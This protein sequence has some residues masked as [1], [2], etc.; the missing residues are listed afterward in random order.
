MWYLHFRIVRSWSDRCLGCTSLGPYTPAT[1]LFFPCSMY[2]EPSAFGITPTSSFTGRSSSG[3]LPSSLR[4][5]LSINFSGL[6]FISLFPPFWI[7]HLLT[8]GL[9]GRSDRLC[10]TPVR[11]SILLSSLIVRLQGFFLLLRRLR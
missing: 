1:I 7:F 4:P 3:F 5:F 6:S 10:E 2:A 11:S 8:S 9:C